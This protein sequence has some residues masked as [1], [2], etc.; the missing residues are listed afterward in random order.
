MRY[1]IGS[2]MQQRKHTGIIVISHERCD[3]LYRK[4][5]FN[6]RCTLRSPLLKN[7]V[8]QRL[9][10]TIRKLQTA[11]QMHIFNVTRRQSTWNIACC[12]RFCRAQQEARPTGAFS[13]FRAHK[14]HFRARWWVFF[15]FTVL[16]FFMCFD[17]V[18]SFIAV[19]RFCCWEFMGFF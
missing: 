13:V 9:A 4:N 1:I 18:L 15:S 3:I 10:G 8:L 14:M 7:T 12:K 2:Q 6:K 5:A 11:M 19:G 17:W 16:F